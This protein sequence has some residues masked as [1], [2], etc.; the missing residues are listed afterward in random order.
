MIMSSLLAFFLSNAYYQFYL[1]PVN[2]A[3]LTKMAEDVKAFY[4]EN[5][6][7]PAGSYLTHVSNLGYQLYLVTDKNK[8]TFYGHAFRKNTL[9]R[10]TI[11]TVLSGGVY[12]GIR[13][14]P[15]KIFITGFFENDLKNTIG[16]P[17][18]INKK[19]YA[20]FMRPDTELQIGE[21]RIF[22]AVLLL[23]TFAI[24]VLLVVFSTRYLVAPITK[25]TEAT[26]S[27]SSGKYNIQLNVKRRD[28]IGRLASHFSQMA[29]SLDQLEASRQEFVSNVSHEI[30]SPL[31]SIQGFSQTLQSRH[32]PEEERQHYLT[33]I[34]QESRRMSQL[35]KQL[36]TLASLDK[37]ESLLDK[38]TYDLAA[39]LKQVILMTEW[40]WRE[41]ELAIDLELPEAFLYG[42][43]NLLHQVWTNLITN[44]IKYTEPGGTISIS[45]KKQEDHCIVRITDTGIGISKKDQSF[46]FDRFYKADKARER[47]QASSGL[48]LAIVKKI[49][50][51]HDG[52]IDVQ[53]EPGKGTAFQVTLPRR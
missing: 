15:S 2:D 26:K 9:D 34:E 20:M 21:L 30:Q 13:D 8:G 28:E 32:L 38:K 51:L 48:G 23:L 37:E 45:L 39:Q 43:E 52:K 53:S 27:I 4:D 47:K 7:D 18:T 36:L 40:H 11:Q 35:S 12:H 49:I 5:P 22:L 25:L 14:Y 6:E 41:K 3:K 31:A 33:I 16:L 46:I 29:K 50:D 42:D 10:Q 44:S 1:K 19:P 17:V 24:S